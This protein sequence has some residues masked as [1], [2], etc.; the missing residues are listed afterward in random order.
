MRFISLGMGFSPGFPR[1]ALK[2]TIEVELF[3]ATL[4]RCFPLLKQGAP[5]TKEEVTVV[6][7]YYA[8]EPPALRPSSAYLLHANGDCDPLSL[9]RV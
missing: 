9:L 5:T 7:E 6:M 8:S 2:R 3:S 1:P 4:K